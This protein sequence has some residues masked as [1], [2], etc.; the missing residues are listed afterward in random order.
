L[1]V[2][3]KLQTMSTER[4]SRTEQAV[5]L[6][7]QA[8]QALAALE[9]AHAEK[10]LLQIPRGLRDRPI[11]DALAAASSAVQEVRSLTERIKAGLRDQS[12][13]GLLP[14]VN[15]LLTLKP[16]DQKLANLAQQLRHRRQR[17]DSATT[18]QRLAMAK[19]LYSESKYS[20]AAE[21]LQAVSDE[22]I[23]AEHRNSYDLVRELDWLVRCLKREPYWHPSLPAVAQRWRTL[24]PNDQ[25]AARIVDKLSKCA[26]ARPP[27]PHFAMPWTKSPEQTALGCPVEWWCGLNQVSS[28][29]GL[30][31]YKKTRS[32]FMTAYGL[33]LQGL[34][35]ARLPLNLLPQRNKALLQRLPTLRKP[36]TLQSVW[37]CDLGSSGLKALKLQKSGDPDQLEIT[38]AVFL[39]HA[40]P[41]AEATDDEQSRAVLRKTM[42]TFF[43]EHAEGPCS[44]VLGVA[45]PRSLGRTF[46][47][48]VFKGKKATDAIAY[49]ARMQIPIPIEDIVYDWYAWPTL[50]ER[51]TFQQVTLLAARRNH[52]T[53]LIQACAELPIK[54]VALQSVC[55]ALYNAVIAEFFPSSGDDYDEHDAVA[56]EGSQPAVAVLDVGAESSTL[57]IVSP[58]LVRHRSLALGT[59][60]IDR[61]LMSRFN[62]TRDQAAQ[63]GNHGSSGR[64][65]YQVDE[66]AGEVFSDLTRD[67]SRTLRA[68][69]AEGIRIARL[70]VT[71]GGSQQLGLLR[72]LVHGNH[73]NLA[74]VTSERISVRD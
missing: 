55:L 61:G 9:F 5:R 31:A 13:D 58:H 63:L 56:S 50:S 36:P 69:E 25:E 26:S 48:P 11:N 54:V 41:L 57:V 7:T 3:D 24:R 21:Q 42:S 70:L 53:Q 72:Q 33:A 47:V 1:A 40:L 68:Y 51:A 23:P 32:R 45:S 2:R 27:N 66:V 62:L 20:K 46:E 22:S 29:G 49:E 60:R 19:K 4:A 28:G 64:W 30:D 12:F 59:H 17:Q 39:P 44:V 10:L 15:R 37:G 18:L 67:V 35:S 43:D 65:M 71:G 6:F 14:Y 52:I 16:H 73:V 38:Q 34:S 74:A 8:Q